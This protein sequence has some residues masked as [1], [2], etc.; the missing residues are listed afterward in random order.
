MLKDSGRLTSNVVGERYH[1]RV[2]GRPCLETNG[3]C[4][5]AALFSWKALLLGRSWLLEW[6]RQK[7]WLGHLLAVALGSHK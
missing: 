4:N 3:H 1:R 6:A 5:V 2:S 7:H